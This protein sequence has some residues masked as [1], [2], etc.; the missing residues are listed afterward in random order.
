MLFQFL[1]LFF[2]LIVGAIA[3]ICQIEWNVEAGSVLL[4]AVAGGLTVGS[5]EVF[6]AVGRT[7]TAGRTAASVD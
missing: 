1:F 5:Y 3:S 7:M 6:S 2:A 4:S